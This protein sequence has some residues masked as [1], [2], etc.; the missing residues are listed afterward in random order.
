MRV[1]SLN[2]NG[3][4]SAERKGLSRW[5]EKAAG[6]WDVLC[7]Q[8]LKA[9]EAG[10]IEIEQDQ[11]RARAQGFPLRPLQSAQ[12]GQAIVKHRNLPEDAVA[13]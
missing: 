8:E 5:L 11:Q 6:P 9:A 7:I 3:I 13:I 10:Q 1:I 2:V 4:R 12:G